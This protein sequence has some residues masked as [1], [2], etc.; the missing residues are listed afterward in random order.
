MDSIKEKIRILLKIQKS[1]NTE[2]Q[3][4][5]IKIKQQITEIDENLERLSILDRSTW[6]QLIQEIQWRQL[7]NKII[8]N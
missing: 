3:D 1:K 4:A 2:Q 5:K 8:N 7:K 6:S